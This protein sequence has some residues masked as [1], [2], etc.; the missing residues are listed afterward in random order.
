[1]GALALLSLIFLLVT[2]PTVLLKW[3]MT[4]TLTH[5]RVW[6]VGIKDRLPL[7]KYWPQRGECVMEDFRDR[8]TIRDAR[9]SKHGTNIVASTIAIH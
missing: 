8:A 6:S 1:M 3:L 5:Y 2:G 4:R 9:Q 7:P